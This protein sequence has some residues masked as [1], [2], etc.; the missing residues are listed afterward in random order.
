MKKYYISWK[1]TKSSNT[2]RM[3]QNAHYRNLNWTR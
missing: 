3:S 2:V 1:N